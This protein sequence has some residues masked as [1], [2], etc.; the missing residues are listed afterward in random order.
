MKITDKFL[1]FWGDDDIYSNFYPSKFIIDDNEFIFTE[2]YFMYQKA[3]VFDDI[4]IAEMILTSQH[5]LECKKLGR[6][7]KNYDDSIWSAK[8]ESVMFDACLAKFS[9]NLELKKQLLDTQNRVIVE[10]SPY[11]KIWGIGL[12]ENN[13]NIEDI[14][15]WRGKNLLG[16]TLMAVRKKIIDDNL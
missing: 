12:S 15:K 9:Q 1:F 4:D 13:P 14:S 7:V 8:R 5:P 11:D 6:K 2:Q 16:K 10:A 3:I